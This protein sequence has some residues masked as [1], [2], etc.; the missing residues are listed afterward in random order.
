M[1]VI[2]LGHVVSQQGIMVDPS[3]IEA[4]CGWPRTTSMVEVQ[5]FS[6]L[7]RYNR[8]F[9]EGFTTIVAPLTWLIHHC[10]LLVWFDVCETTFLRLKEL[11][12]TSLF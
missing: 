9:I 2:F 1:P 7:A 11:L 6:R 5:I 8:Q 4:I 12:T 10:V 3:M